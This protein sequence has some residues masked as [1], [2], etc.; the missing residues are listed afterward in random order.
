M[1]RLYHATVEEYSPSI[2]IGPFG[3]STFF[4]QRQ[5]AEGQGW[6]EQLLE[7]E[8]PGNRHSRMG[9]IFACETLIDCGTY[10]YSE[11]RHRP[12]SKRLRFYEIDMHDFT[13]AP[14]VLVGYAA[15][16]KFEIS[17]CQAIVS[18][19][20]TPTREW[21]YLEQFGPSAT[22]AREVQ[23]PGPAQT[24]PLFSPFADDLENAKRLWPTKTPAAGT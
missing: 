7:K 18:E 6:I 12:S 13:T 11:K 9:A 15:R 8:R 5:S 23:G 16:F 20:W 1:A 19:Y 24:S 2:V 22:I 3:E 10:A 17:I 14:M 21:G 4:Q